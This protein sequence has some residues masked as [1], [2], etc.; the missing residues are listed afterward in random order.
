[1]R[2]SPEPTWSVLGHVLFMLDRVA[3]TPIHPLH[4]E[5]T[6]AAK[7]LRT[8]REYGNM[9]EFLDAELFNRYCNCLRELRRSVGSKRLLI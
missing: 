9:N 5:K 2:Q 3:P 1:M 6:M 4:A 8:N 7:V